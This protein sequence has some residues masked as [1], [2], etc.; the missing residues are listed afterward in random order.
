LPLLATVQFETVSTPAFMTRIA[1]SSVLV[2]LK[3]RSA[4]LT[5]PP[6]CWYYVA[7]GSTIG[8]ARV[9]PGVGVAGS[10]PEVADAVGAIV[11]GNAGVSV[12]VAVAVTGCV[13]GAV[14]VSAAT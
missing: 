9:G 13:G 14:A 6:L 1:D 12:M 11:A 8:R 5:L 2:A 3:L 10:T 4:R 7:A